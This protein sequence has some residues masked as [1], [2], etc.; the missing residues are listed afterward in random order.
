MLLVCG[1]SGPGGICIFL[2]GFSLSL[3][4]CEL[5]YLFKHSVC[6]TLILCVPACWSVFSCLFQL[7]VCLDRGVLCLGRL[8]SCL[9]ILPFFCPQCLL[10]CF[11]S[12]VLCVCVCVKRI[13]RACMSVIEGAAVE[14]ATSL[15]P[16]PC[17]SLPPLC[18]TLFH[19]HS[20]SFSLSFLSLTLFAPTPPPPLTASPL[21]SPHPHSHPP[22]HV[23]S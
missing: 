3:R 20:L 6:M 15:P 16:P 2:S 10:I 1:F 22:T 7:S 13:I 17:L 8:A 19:T 9:L 18:Y 4:L 12:P 14:A 23:M 11:S 5:M 21:Y